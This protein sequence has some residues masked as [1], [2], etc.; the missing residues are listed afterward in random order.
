[1]A[2]GRVN[3]PQPP[4][5]RPLPRMQDVYKHTAWECR[6]DSGSFFRC[7]W[8]KRVLEDPSLSGCLESFSLDDYGVRVA[9]SRFPTQ[10]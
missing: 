9:D 5:L 7:P 4:P 2:R 6:G 1:M 8:E 3:Q 10:V